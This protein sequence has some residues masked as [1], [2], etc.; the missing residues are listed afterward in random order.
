VVFVE[1]ATK[2]ASSPYGRVH[3]H[4]DTPIVVGWTLI[5]TLMRR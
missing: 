4:D 3:R 2:D 1:D 5:K